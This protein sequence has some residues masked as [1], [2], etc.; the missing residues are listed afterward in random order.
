[1]CHCC[2]HRWHQW[3]PG[4][5]Y[6]YQHR[7]EYGYGQGFGPGFARGPRRRRDRIEELEDYLGDLEEEITEV[8]AELDELRG[9]AQTQK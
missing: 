8:K 4:Q 2:G 1:M 6:G 5:H 3:G 7:R 9:P